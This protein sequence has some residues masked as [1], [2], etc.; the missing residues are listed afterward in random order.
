VPGAARYAVYR[1]DDPPGPCGPADAAYR[2]AV[3]GGTT[4]T[5]TGAEPGKHYVYRVTAVDRLWHESRP[6]TG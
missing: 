3:T 2:I 6:A 5:D 4:Y 1:F